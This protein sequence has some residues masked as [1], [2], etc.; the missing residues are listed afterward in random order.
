MHFY[1]LTVIRYSTALSGLLKLARSALTTL[2]LSNPIDMIFTTIFSYSEPVTNA[3]SACVIL[4]P[5]AVVLLD[6]VLK[7]AIIQEL[8][9]IEGDLNND[10]KRPPF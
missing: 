6:V 10:V 4:N 7:R 2:S 3:D 9:V 5:V 1:K 8:S